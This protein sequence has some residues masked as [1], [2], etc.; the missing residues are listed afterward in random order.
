M[1]HLNA[2]V[3][4]KNRSPTVKFCEVADPVSSSSIVLST[5]E[6]IERAYT[7]L[8]PSHQQH[9]EQQPPFTVTMNWSLPHTNAYKRLVMYYL[10]EGA[11]IILFGERAIQQEGQ[12]LI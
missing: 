7:E 3:S 9:L 6:E 8:P 2:L 1:N 4:G 11:D 10:S 5:S 12:A